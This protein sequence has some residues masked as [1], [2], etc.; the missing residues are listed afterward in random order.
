MNDLTKRAADTRPVL[1]LMH[2]APTFNRH[3]TKKD[4]NALCSG[5]NMHDFQ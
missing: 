3:E 1:K 5:A 2:S 4:R